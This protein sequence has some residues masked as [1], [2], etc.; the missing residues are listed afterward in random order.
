M[1]FNEC[2]QINE[3]TNC[4]K[5]QNLMT[6][7]YWQADNNQSF[8]LHHVIIQSYLIEYVIKIYFKLYIY[9]IISK[10]LIGYNNFNITLFSFYHPPSKH[11]QSSYLVQTFQFIHLFQVTQHIFFGIQ[12]LDIDKSSLRRR[13]DNQINKQKNLIAE[14]FHDHLAKIIK[15]QFKCEM[16]QNGERTVERIN[17]RSIIRIYK[18]QNGFISEQL[19]IK[20]KIA[21]M[22]QVL[23]ILILASI[24]FAQSQL[25]GRQQI[26]KQDV[27]LE[28]YSFMQFHYHTPPMDVMMMNH[29]LEIQ[30]M[31]GVPGVVMMNYVIEESPYNPISW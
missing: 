8:F 19:I 14:Y 30:R 10:F 21:K 27:S 2:L 12:H 5:G 11:Y 15:F 26:E 1:R 28:D 31:M 7:D 3:Y 6:I 23:F 25:R 22:R 16:K 9:K 18:I 20:G 24:C 17:W 29:E 13:M 4:N